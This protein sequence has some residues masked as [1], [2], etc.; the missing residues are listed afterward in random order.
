[1]TEVVAVSS[2]LIR[3]L[4]PLDVFTSDGPKHAGGHHQKKLLAALVLGANHAVTIDHLAEILWGEEAPPS[5]DNTL[6][7]YVYRLRHL[8]GPDAILSKDHS[9]ELVV[10]PDQLDALRFERLVNQAESIRDDPDRS[11]LLWREALSMWRGDPFGEFGD[12]DPFRL[13]S[14]RLVELRLLAMERRLECDIAMDRHEMV[15]GALEGLVEENPYN[16]KLWYLLI[17]ALAGSGRRVDSL[18]AFDRLLEVLAEVGLEPSPA[19]KDL[20]ELV[21]T[22]GDIHSNRG[23]AGQRG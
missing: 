10:E 18:R 6:Q 16:E 14:L 2:F 11:G 9:Y 23:S 1:M 7:S 15:V 8:I 22:G 5:R 13:E 12:E 21:I 17:E 3:V 19:L 4:G 20:E